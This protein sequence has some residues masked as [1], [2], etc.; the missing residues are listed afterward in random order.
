LLKPGIDV[1]HASVAKYRLRL[2]R[3]PSQ[4]WRTFL[5]NHVE[6]I[7]AADFF[8][9]ATA[10]GRVLFVFVM[11]AHHRRRVLHVA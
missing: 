8:V 5:T 1:S 7:M 3:P 2:R 9:V 10:T 6:Q 11:L 4:S